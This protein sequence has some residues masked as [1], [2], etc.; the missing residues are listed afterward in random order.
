MIARVL[1]ASP[2]IPDGDQAQQWAEE[3]LSNPAYD[4]AEPT[5]FDRLAAWVVNTVVDL[6]TG[7]TFQQWGWDGTAALITLSILVTLL[8]IGL[9]IWGVPRVRARARGDESPLELF[10]E[11]EHRS[12]SQLRRLAEEYADNGDWDNAI[13]FR[14]RA[15]ARAAVEQELAT[16]VPGLTA[17][18]F[19]RAIAQTAP[20]IGA[21][22][23]DAADTFDDVRYLRRSGTQQMYERI[24]RA[25]EHVDEARVPA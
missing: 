10:G 9:V 15:L 13:V 23:A 3:E 14:F 6:F 5:W 4:A 7:K 8:V 19:A 2:L 25:D 16:V 20:T 12:I 1:A 11:V 18:A 22:V 17:Q 21:D 24:V